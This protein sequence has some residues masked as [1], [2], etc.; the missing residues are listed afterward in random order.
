MSIDYPVSSLMPRCGFDYE[1]LSIIKRS[2]GGSGVLYWDDVL[3]VLMLLLSLILLLLV[4]RGWFKPGVHRFGPP[5]RDQIN[6]PDKIRE[7]IDRSID[8][9]AVYNI[10]VYD[11]NYKEIYKCNVLRVN[12]FDEIEVELDVFSDLTLDFKDKLVGVAFRM[13]RRGKQEFFHFDTISA[14]LDFTEIDGR[15]PKALRLLMPKQITK[16]Q[17]RRH[18]RLNPRGRYA[19][20]VDLIDPIR[21]LRPKS[22]AE[23]KPLHEGEVIDFS[24]GGMQTLVRAG[25][26]ELK[27]I[28]RQDVYLR[29]ALPKAGLHVDH[30]PDEFLVQAKIIDI[31]QLD[32]QPAGSDGS[33]KP[34]IVRPS[35]IRLMFTG[36]G[37]EHTEERDVNFRPVTPVL[38]EDL[39]R[40]LQAYQR[41]IIQEEK[42]SR[43]N[44]EE[45]ASA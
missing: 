39:S 3:F 38:F 45:T 30:V 26:N 35:M 18:L 27:L 16:A 34:M 21:Q 1:F 12:P 11:D 36:R 10:E 40:W 13:S 15:R 22:F 44:A 37:Y 24:I 25:R 19:F 42:D 8:L 41:H 43:R 17:K 14:F 33:G 6:D 20:N 2:F 7:I 29:F 9:R 5:D 32:A 31:Q 4:L 28:P 23:Y